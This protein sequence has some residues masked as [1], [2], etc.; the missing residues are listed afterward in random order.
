MERLAN[1]Y[2]VIRYSPDILRGEILNI[3]IIVNN[4]DSKE[5]HFQFLKHT[6]TKLKSLL[7]NQSSLELYKAHSD[8]ITFYLEQIIKRDS[9]FVNA[10]DNHIFNHL[11][12]IVPSEIIFSEPTFALTGDSHALLNSL[13]ATYIGEEYLVESEITQSK[14]RQYVRQVFNDKHLL[15]YKVKAN[16]KI[17]PIKDKHSISYNVDFVYK[18]GMV[19]LMQAAPSK[20]NM[21][22]WFNKLNTF[23]D[24]YSSET[25]YH[26][27]LNSAVSE[28][29]DQTFKEM[30]E[31]LIERA[32]ENKFH[33][34]DINSNK[35]E[36]LCSKIEISG[37]LLENFQDDLNNVI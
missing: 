21:H 8:Y 14:I 4:V 16:A 5:L 3:G 13:M 2:S 33:L 9:I 36:E 12:E 35:F 19:N 6:N 28:I 15:D 1:W 17:Y 30:V 25:V 22:N 29:K 24:N 10:T 26:V 27:L 20:D 7:I 11:K 31:Y 23:I 32:P 34:I 18:N 37:Q